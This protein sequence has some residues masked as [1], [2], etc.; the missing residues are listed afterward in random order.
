[1]KGVLPMKL[2]KV[3]QKYGRQVA[4]G[5]AVALLGMGS[6]MAALPAVV[7]TTVTNIQADGQSIFDLV[8]P[9]VG[10]FLG[11]ALIIKLF[12]RFSNKI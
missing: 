11:M 1:M 12:K 8:F 10:L 2:F 7:G 6:A 9:V 3:A 5:S 4:A